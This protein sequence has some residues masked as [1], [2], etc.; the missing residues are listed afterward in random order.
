M[1]YFPWNVAKSLMLPDKI[2][3]WL[4]SN[5]IDA[6]TKMRLFYFKTFLKVSLLIKQFDKSLCHVVEVSF[7][8]N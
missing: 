1:I 8:K 2:S 4:A 5:R 3:F 6:V 7:Y